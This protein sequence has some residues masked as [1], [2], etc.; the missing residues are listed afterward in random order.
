M[1]K[2]VNLRLWLISLAV[3]AVVIGLSSLI[4]Q[5]DVTF[6]IVD[7][8]AAASAE[9]VDEIQAQWRE[10]GVRTFA[11]VAVVADLLWIW[12][13]ALGS[14]VAGRSFASGRGAV[15]YVAGLIICAAAI[16]FAIADYTE[17]ILQFI[18]LLNENGD[19]TMARLAA[20]AQPIKIS[21]FLI[22]FVGIVAAWMIN[23]FTGS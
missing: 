9:R 20:T 3:F 23:R 4:T 11:I 6:G 16:I 15:L 7:H 5:G 13:Y 19:D 21:A 2:N 8:Q 18:Q 22:A 1:Q 12:L 10:G 14:F 17:T